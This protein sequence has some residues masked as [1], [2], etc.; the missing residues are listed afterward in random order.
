MIKNRTHKNI[1]GVW[2]GI[3]RRT[4]QDDDSTDD[5]NNDDE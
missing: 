1:R 5:E 3:I 2:D 4:S